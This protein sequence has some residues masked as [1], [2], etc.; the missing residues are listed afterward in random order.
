V[1]EPFGEKAS[2]S[3]NG[4]TNWLGKRYFMMHVARPLL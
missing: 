3:L 1:N 4:D 2:T